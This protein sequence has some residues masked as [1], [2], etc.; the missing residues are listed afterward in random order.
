MPKSKKSTN[1]TPPLSVVPT[2]EAPNAGRAANASFDPMGIGH[3]VEDQ[4]LVVN[5]LAYVLQQAAMGAVAGDHVG[6]PE[7]EDLFDTG[8]AEI[9]RLIQER[10]AAVIDLAYHGK[11]SDERATA[12]GAQ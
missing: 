7:L 11:T 5:A 2:P 4:L 1:P 12:G 8:T 3:Q 9:L 6:D 10:T